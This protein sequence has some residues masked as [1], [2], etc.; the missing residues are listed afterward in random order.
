MG[1]YSNSYG[2]LK[3]DKKSLL[4]ISTEKEIYFI[5]TI[6]PVWGL[7]IIFPFSLP[8]PSKNF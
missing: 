3:K 6:F 1:I 7:G 4:G 2:F 5:G 8:T